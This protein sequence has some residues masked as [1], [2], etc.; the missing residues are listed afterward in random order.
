MW[1][2][3]RI[4]RNWEMNFEIEAR[5]YLRDWLQLNAPEQLHLI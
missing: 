5:L 3:G 4:G 1:T 2:R